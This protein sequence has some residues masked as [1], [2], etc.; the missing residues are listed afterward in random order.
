MGRG[1]LRGQRRITRTARWS[2][3]LIW[4][5]STYMEDSQDE[6]S[7]DVPISCS[8]DVQKIFQTFFGDKLEHR[9]NKLFGTSLEQ[10]TDT[11]TMCIF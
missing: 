11:P 3:G 2:D 7:S 5:S 8:G 10:C 9:Q 4:K 6:C 1:S